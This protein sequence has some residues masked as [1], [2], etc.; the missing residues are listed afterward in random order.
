MVFIDVFAHL[1][2]YT[3]RAAAWEEVTRT[4]VMDAIA[5][6]TITHRFILSLPIV[7]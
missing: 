5:K 2:T 4:A 1:P 3:G 6:D 7:E